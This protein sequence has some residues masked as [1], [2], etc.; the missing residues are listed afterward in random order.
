MALIRPPT[1]DPRTADSDQLVLGMSAISNPRDARLQPTHW[2]RQRAPALPRGNINIAVSYVNVDVT[3][4]GRP[5]Q[6]NR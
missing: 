4:G 6:R 5:R 3:I 1:A 2:L